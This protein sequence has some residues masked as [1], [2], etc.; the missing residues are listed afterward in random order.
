LTRLPKE[1]LLFFLHNLLL[2]RMETGTALRPVVSLH[3]TTRVLRME[4]RDKPLSV[5]H[6]ASRSV[7]SL[8]ENG[9][10]FY[11]HDRC[12]VM[13]SFFWIDCV[14]WCFTGVTGDT[15]INMAP[16]DTKGVVFRRL[17]FIFPFVCTYFLLS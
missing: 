12:I 17:K 1:P 14:G 5:E 9:G 13:R 8:L 7:I 11:H 15:G 4:L 16:R 6:I 3:L 2:Q 10:R